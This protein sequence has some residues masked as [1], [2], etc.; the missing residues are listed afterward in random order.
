MLTAR[1]SPIP[2]QAHAGKSDFFEGATGMIVDT[3]H[4]WLWINIKNTPPGKDEHSFRLERIDLA[5]GTVLAPIPLPSLIKL[6]AV[7]PSGRYLAMLREDDFHN[8]GQPLDL[9][10]IDGQEVKPGQTF[11][12]YNR[13][14]GKPHSI[15][16]VKWG[17]FVDGTHLLT[18]SDN[19]TLA[20]WNLGAMKCEWI[21][22]LGGWSTS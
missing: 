13:G 12:P 3:A 17:E 8:R 19:G 5:K 22:E 11:K 7:D 4:N 18:L 10:E 20:M 2:A 15:N 6:L 21:A 14:D 9:W 16:S 1:I